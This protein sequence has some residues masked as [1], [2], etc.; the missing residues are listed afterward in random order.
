MGTKQVGFIDAG[1]DSVCGSRPRLCWD[2]ASG[3]KK[4]DC[5]TDLVSRD[6]KALRSGARDPTA[7]ARVKLN[8]R[9]PQLAPPH[10][11]CESRTK[12]PNLC[13]VQ[14]FSPYCRAFV[15]SCFRDGD[16]GLT[17]TITKARKYESTKKREKTCHR[18]F[19]IGC[20]S[21]AVGTTRRALPRF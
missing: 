15:L 17:K 8:K 1:A 3:R 5:R 2:K 16:F 14:R 4:S 10:L 13:A 21:A 19:F 9:P 12:V 6:A 18:L 7:H 11:R 20:G